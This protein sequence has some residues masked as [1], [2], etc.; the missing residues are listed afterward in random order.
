MVFEIYETWYG[1]M[2]GRLVETKDFNTEEEA[3]VYCECLGEQ[4]EDYLFIP[5]PLLKTK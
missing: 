2:D 4:N 3:Q 1:D 5:I